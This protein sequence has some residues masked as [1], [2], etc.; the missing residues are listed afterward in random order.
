MR[1]PAR[2]R[3][4]STSFT[5]SSSIGNMFSN[6]KGLVHNQLLRRLLLSSS[7][8]Y[9]RIHIIKKPRLTPLSSVNNGFWAEEA[10]TFSELGISKVVEEAMT[11]QGFTRPS[12]VQVGAC[13]PSML[14]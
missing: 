14:S 5:F 1:I 2:I 9:S 4:Q 7:K 3:A 8:A 10:R 6:S 11:R 12:F 13:M